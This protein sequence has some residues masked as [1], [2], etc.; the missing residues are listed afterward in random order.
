MYQFLEIF[1]FNIIR[2]NPKISE[3]KHDFN[4]SQRHK[5]FVSKLTASDNIAEDLISNLFEST[6]RCFISSKHL[7]C[8]MLGTKLAVHFQ[9]GISIQI[10]LALYDNIIRPFIVK[11]KCCNR[12]FFCGLEKVT[13]SHGNFMCAMLPDCTINVHG[14][15]TS[16]PDFLSCFELYVSFSIF[17]IIFQYK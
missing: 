5:C 13:H 9:W 15:L 3:C 4:T 17:K 1:V 6:F 2:K 11:R 10:I 8:T 12:F 7:P 16:D 14:C